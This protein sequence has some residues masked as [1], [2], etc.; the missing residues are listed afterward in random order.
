MLEDP[1]TIICGLKIIMKVLEVEKAYIGIEDD[2]EDAISIMQSAIVKESQIEIVPLKAKYPQGAEKQLIKVILDREVPS[3]GLPLDVG[4]VVH[5]VGTAVAIANAVISGVPLID[6]IVCVTGGGVAR[7]SNLKIRIGTLFSDVINDC[8]G[9]R[10]EI[11]KIVMGG[12]MMGLAQYTT[13]VPVIKATSGILVLST[14][15]VKITPSKVCIRCGMCLDACPM[16]LMPSV[17][18]NLIENNCITEAKEND[19]LDCVECGSCTYVC[20]SKRPLV[21]YIKFAKLQLSKEKK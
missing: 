18:G 12:P 9:F 20:P 10:G 4:V 19:V 3:G 6:R 8:G 16:Y 2:K 14:D 7:P 17:L 13:E 21:H 11:S 5:N 15:E 1:N